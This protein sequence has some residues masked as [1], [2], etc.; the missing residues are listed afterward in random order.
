M[1][2]RGHPILAAAVAALVAAP[3]ATTTVG[4]CPCPVFQDPSKDCQDC[5][6]VRCRIG[7]WEIHRQLADATWAY[8]AASL[9]VSNCMAY[10]KAAPWTSMSTTCKS[11][12]DAC[13]TV[14][15]KL[16][17]PDTSCTYRCSLA[18]GSAA[19]ACLSFPWPE[20]VAEPVS[21][22]AGSSSGMVYA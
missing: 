9:W 19:H 2:V 22:S 10:S 15:G 7:G 18:Q 11:V 3:A 16:F 20:E 21:G 13:G 1:P 17:P 8:D 14:C 4:T 6:R 12:M 5:H